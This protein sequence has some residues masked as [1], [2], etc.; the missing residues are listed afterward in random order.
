MQNAT[1]DGDR[2]GETE[3]PAPRVVQGK[4]IPHRDLLIVLA[5]TVSFHVVF[6]V[7][8][9]HDPE[10]RQMEQDSYG[11]LTLADNLVNGP[12]FAR[13]HA[14]GPQGQEVLTPEF[15]RTPGYPVLIAGFQWLTGHGRAATIVFQQVLSIL[16]CLMTMMICQQFFGRKAG[17]IAGCLLAFDPQVLGLSNVLYADSIF[18]FYLCCAVFLAAKSVEGGSIW[19]SVTAGLLLGIGILTKPAGIVLPFVLAAV[20]VLYGLAKRRRRIIPAAALI[21]IVAY[22]P[23][24]GWVIR[25]GVVCGEYAFCSQPKLAALGLATVSLARSEGISQQVACERILAK[26]GVSYMRLRQTA[27]SPEELRRVREAARSTVKENR[28]SFLVECAIAPAKLFFGPEKMTLLALGLPHIA[29]GIQGDLPDAR[30]VS[31]A[32]V[33]VLAFEILLL[34]A[35]YVLVF[36]TLWKCVR[37]RRLPNLLLICLIVALPILALSSMPGGGDPRYR[38]AVVP[39]LVVI[40][41][42][43]FGLNEQTYGHGRHR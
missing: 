26:T 39:L 5:I 15:C 25:N 34:G 31:M 21:F 38:A 16:L 20:M 36:V 24:F 3:S 9:F 41:A 27:I 18:C 30:N 42:A 13:M 33:A 28:S 37:L 14:V 8:S 22:L 10:H 23:V 29:L 12:G 7:R 17:L 2:V 19:L 4:R 1:A 40:A 32:S 6:S 35:T 11:Y 43:G